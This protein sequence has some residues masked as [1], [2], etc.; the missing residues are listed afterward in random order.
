MLEMSAET[1]LAILGEKLAAVK[2]AAVEARIA[3]LEDTA[4]ELFDL[5]REVD[6]RIAKLEAAAK[7]TKNDIQEG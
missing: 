3:K 6:V 7:I 5:W 1:E 4:A 2:L